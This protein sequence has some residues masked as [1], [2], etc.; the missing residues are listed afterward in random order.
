MW[1]NGLCLLLGWLGV[2]LPLTLRGNAGLA[3]ALAILFFWGFV[4]LFS[5]VLILR[6][7]AQS[8]KHGD[9]PITLQPLNWPWPLAAG[10][11]VGLAAL[12]FGFCMNSFAGSGH[13]VGLHFGLLGLGLAFGVLGVF[14][15]QAFPIG[16]AFGLVV[17]TFYSLAYPAKVERSAHAAAQGNPYCIYLNQR[18]RFTQNN[19][20]LTFLTFDKGNWQAHAILIIE[21]P[22]GPRYG[23]WSYRQGTFMVPWD[24]HTPEPT[25][26]CPH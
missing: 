22:D 13:A 17:L 9:Q 6:M 25:L 24:L 15:W 3:D 14:L 10:N 12:I 18:R 1:A 19:R 4:I 16:A 20:D 8:M 21:G 5:T 11:G 23:N 7:I 2:Q 26:Q